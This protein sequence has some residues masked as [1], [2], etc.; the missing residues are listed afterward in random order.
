MKSTEKPD[1]LTQFAAVAFEHEGVEYWSARELQNLLGYS[2]WRNFENTI[3]KAKEACRNLGENV[4]YHFADV[5]KV[6]EAGKGAQHEINDI[7]LTRYACYLI[8]Q[9]GDI[10]KPEITHAQRY[11]SVNPTAVASPQKLN[12]LSVQEGVTDFLLYTTPDGK[13]KVEAIMSNETI[14]LTQDHIAQLFGVQKPAISKHF[15]NIFESGELEEDRCVSI[16]ETHLPDGR[17]YDL[18]YYNLDAVISVGYRVNSSRATQFRIWAT[19]TLKEYIIKGFVMDDDRLKN[20]RYFGKDYFEELLER[21]RSIRASERR[22]YQKITD[23]FAECSIDYDRKSVEATQFYATVQ[24]KFHYAITGNTAAEI[25][26]KEAD[27][28]KDFMGLKTWKSAPQGRILKSDAK[29]AKNYLNENQIKRLE[30][31]INAYFDYIENLIERRQSFTMQEFANSVNRFLEFNEYKI[32][33]GKGKISH[34][35]AETKAIQEYEEFNKRQQIES[36]FDRIV[37][38]LSENQNEV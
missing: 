14:W 2:Q 13:I 38:R 31:S 29:I 30:R 5:S 4:E 6:I 12:L 10:R 19:N 37:K 33:E 20:G 23:I 28:K 21:I 22:I 32:L 35:Q 7:H 3:D 9:N 8:A 17:K 1:I 24:N 36:D 11:F 15:K 26:Y 25:I 18:R 34:K 27:A 16:L